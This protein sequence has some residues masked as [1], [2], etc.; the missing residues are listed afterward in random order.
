MTA[1]GAEAEGWACKGQG[2]M[3]ASVE[4]KTR[5]R[6]ILCRAVQGWREGG[7]TD[8]ETDDGRE[9][10]DF[11]GGCTRSR[12][13]F[14]LAMPVDGWWGRLRCVWNKRVGEVLVGRQEE[15]ERRLLLPT[16]DV[17]LPPSTSARERAEQTGRL[18]VFHT[19]THA[20]PSFPF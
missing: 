11:F 12:S 4:E 14:G 6:A 18:V 17:W 20:H 5:I 15:K 2:L 8:V 7:G 3:K 1:A 16:G 10:I 13:D 19:R 9:I